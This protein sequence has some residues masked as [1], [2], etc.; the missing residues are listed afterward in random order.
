MLMIKRMSDLVELLPEQ[1][2]GLSRAELVRQ[3]KRKGHLGS[4]RTLQRDLNYLREQGYDIQFS[5]KNG[6]LCVGNK[7]RFRTFLE[8]HEETLPSLVLM[9]T[10]LYSVHKADPGAG[11]NMLTDHLDNL[12]KK[13]SLNFN[14]L[15]NY[16][17]ST[18][19]PMSEKRVPI[20]RVLV[21]GLLEKRAVKIFYKGNKDKVARERMLYP[22][23]LLEND[24][25]W[26]CVAYCCDSKK[27]KMFASW[28]IDKAALT[29]ETFQRPAKW[30][31]PKTMERQSEVFGL[32]NSDQDPVQVR[33]KMW[34]YAARLIQEAGYR[35]KAMQ[36]QLKPPS[37]DPTAVI[38]SFYVHSFEDITPWILKW[39]A[40]CQVLS[41]P[42]LVD[43]MQ[44]ELKSTL[45][46]YPDP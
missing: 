6:Y 33:L 19:R 2:T 15:P 32:W 38:V 37:D 20:F 22:Y 41:P 42:A 44:A 5:R 9:R 11:A 24:G 17:S 10:L 34:G 40:H 28:R 35:P 43:K 29:D 1:G 3:L 14:D 18:A 4:V 36:V 23:H 46:L 12:L 8:G 21:K 26:Y 25:L 27:N 13:Q 7:E 16:I 45:E 31:D 39:G 30:N